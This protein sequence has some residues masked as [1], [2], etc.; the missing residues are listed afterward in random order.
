MPKSP[1]QDAGLS[2]AVYYRQQLEAERAENIRKAE[3]KP[4]TKT[5]IERWADLHQI[6]FDNG[7]TVVSPP[8]QMRMRFNCEADSGIPDYLRSKGHSVIPAGTAEV[9]RACTEA[10]TGIQMVKP[11]HVFVYELQVQK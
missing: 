7:G 5:Q 10:G 1:W 3:P 2:R 8:G 9:L 6:I 4:L 11:T